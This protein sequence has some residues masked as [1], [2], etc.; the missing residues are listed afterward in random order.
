MSRLLA[1]G[2]RSEALRE[3]LESGDWPGAFEP[4]ELAALNYVRKLTKAPAEISEPDIQ[5]LREAA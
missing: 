2:V 1:D 4:R 5:A 3:A